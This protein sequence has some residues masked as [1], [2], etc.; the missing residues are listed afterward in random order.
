MFTED[1]TAFFNTAEHATAALVGATTVNGIFDE[2]GRDDVG[3]GSTR[4]TFMCAT[5]S[6]PIGYLTANIVING[7]TFK[8]AGKPDPDET[9]A[10]L[11]LELQEQ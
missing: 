9:G 3:I 8:V 10:V 6:L 7:R 2:P 5:A 4:P 11:T 1:L